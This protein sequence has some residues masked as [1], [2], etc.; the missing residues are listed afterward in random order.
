[1][2]AP[3]VHATACVLCECNCGITV[4]LDGRRFAK[5][6]GDKSHPASAGYTCEKAMRLDLYQNG[7]HR[8]TSPLKRMPDGSYVEIDWDTALDE[9]AAKLAAI[10]QRHGGDKIFFYGGGGQGN[11]LGSANALALRGAVGSVY[12]SNALAQ[13]KT[14]EI[15]VDGRLYGGHTKGDYENAEVLVFVGKNPWQSHSFPRARPVL[16]QVAADPKRSMIVVD[17][18]ASETAALADHHLQVSPGCDAWLMAAIVAVIVQEDL[19][20]TAF[21]AAHTT[22]HEQVLAAFRTVDIAA[23]AAKSGVPEEQIRAAARRIATAESVCVYE[24]LGVQQAPNSTLTSYLNKL[25][26]I[27]T[28]NFGRPGTMFLHSTFASLTGGSGGGGERKAPTRLDRAR[29]TVLTRAV[30]IVGKALS[31]ILPALSRVP[32]LQTTVEAGSRSLLEALAP[33]AGGM[34]A[35]GSASGGS[36]RTTPVTGAKII[37]GLIPCNSI[38][39]EILTDHPDR[40]RAIWID[41]SNP[42]HSLADSKRFRAAMRALE[43]SVVIDVAFTETARLADYILPAA[44]QFEKPEA[45]FFN[46]EFPRNVFHLRKP[47]LEPLAGTRCEPEIYAQLLRRM[48]VVDQETLRRLRRAAHTG[49]DTF[50]ATFLATVAAN[51]ELGKVAPYLLYET[52]G[53][54]LPAPVRG[55][56]VLWG[57]AQLC[58]LSNPKGVARA[59]FAGKGLRPGNALFDAVI[60]SPTGVVF[61]DDTWDD[62]WHYVKRK[63]RRFTIAVEDFLDQ[64]R[65]LGAARSVWTSEEFP[66]VLAAGER[67]SFTANTILRN[68]EWR[69]RDKNGNLRISAADAERLRLTD[70]DRARLVTAGGSALVTVEISDM[71][72]AGNIAL[73]NGLGLDFP[74]GQGETT[75]A[76]VAPNELTSTGLKDDFAGTPWHKHVPARLEAVKA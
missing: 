7:P 43:L 31:R 42:A 20:D 35:G 1:M 49:R 22:G 53:E 8:I 75:S 10:M 59:G 33:L 24:D 46:F 26:W 45:T 62:V 4:E 19:V 58:A 29:T 48:H 54:T 66:L 25:V 73:P 57:V 37:G 12:H 2:A 6:R 5:I 50:A 3:E 21:V 72:A 52:L 67:R 76:G 13:E 71:M 74:A 44:S 65:G 9:I 11:H 28:G 64:V 18:R 51:P 41:S 36:G 39:D 38:A 55:A 27:L 16:K 63:D 40:F 69:R 30:P 17:P 61:T 23:F 14:G 15:W 56:A 68:P 47:V 32:A 70:G 60:E 34:L